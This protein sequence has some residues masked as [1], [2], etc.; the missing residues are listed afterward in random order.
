MDEHGV[1]MRLGFHLKVIQSLVPR[2]QGGG[3]AHEGKPAAR[4]TSV[5]VVWQ[6]RLM[7]VALCPLYNEQASNWHRALRSWGIVKSRLIDKK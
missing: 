2:E 7:R 3:V 1:A 5:T 4:L 6:V